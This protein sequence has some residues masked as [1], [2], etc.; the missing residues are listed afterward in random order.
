MVFLQ[1]A[2]DTDLWVLTSES[3]AIPAGADPRK[4]KGKESQMCLLC[5]RPLITSGQVT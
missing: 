4:G 2:W 1:V 3:E 5:H